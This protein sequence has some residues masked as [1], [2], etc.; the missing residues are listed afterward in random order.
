MIHGWPKIIAGPHG[1]YGWHAMG[2]AMPIGPATM[3][4]F[5]AAMVEFGGG[6]LLVLGLFFRPICALLFI[7]MMVAIFRV[8]LPHGDGF[9]AYSHALEDGIVFLGLALIGA[10]V[11][12]LDA[13][14]CCHRSE[15][16]SSLP[17]S[18]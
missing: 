16:D 12:S 14:L 18:R 7:Q 10:G 9:N 11:Y 8:H 2:Q 4:G 13:K 3:W 15:P 17:P 6:I 5:V 1:Q